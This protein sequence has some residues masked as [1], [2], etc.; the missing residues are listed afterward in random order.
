MPI[1]VSQS[2]RHRLSF[3]KR[4]HNH[5][6]L[7]LKKPSTCL[8]IFTT[9]QQEILDLE[10]FSIFVEVISIAI[11]ILIRLLTKLTHMHNASRCGNL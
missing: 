1:K 5:H 9:N 4:D 8:P 2:R 6:L 10:T 7:A 11:A 3:T